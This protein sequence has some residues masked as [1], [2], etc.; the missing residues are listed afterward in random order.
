MKFTNYEILQKSQHVLKTCPTYIDVI[1]TNKP[2][3]FK[4]TYAIET[5]LSDFYEMIVAMMKTHFSKMKPQVVSYRKYK[6]FHN[7]PFSDSLRHELKAQG[8]FLN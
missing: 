6:D 2:L 5:G 8:K 4:I 3:S 1:L 7:K